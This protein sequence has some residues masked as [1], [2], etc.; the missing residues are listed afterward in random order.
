MNE[1]VNSGELASAEVVGQS[2]LPLSELVSDRRVH[3]SVYTDQAIF[4]LEMD[5][6]F[7]NT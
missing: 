2:G 6:N 1:Q 5:R 4:D 3:S 7:T